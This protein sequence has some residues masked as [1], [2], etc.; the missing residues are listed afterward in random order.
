MI[1]ITQ[2]ITAMESPSVGYE[3]I[4]RNIYRNDLPNV[5][6][7]FHIMH[8]D[9]VKIYNLCLV[10]NRIY[11]KN[12]L[13]KSFIGLFPATEHNRCR[14][15]L[16]LEFCIDTCLVLLKNPKSIAGIH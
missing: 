6:E 12:I 3:T 5:L 16:I 1:Y 8:N 14:I 9:R 10:K 4:Y 13:S 7:F 2:R 15:K 11:N